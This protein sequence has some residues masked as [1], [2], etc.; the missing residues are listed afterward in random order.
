MNA[1]AY[2]PAVSLR[3]GESTM[4]KS[5][6]KYRPFDPEKIV[7]KSYHPP[8][9]HLTIPKQPTTPPKPEESAEKK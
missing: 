6:P 9:E 8:S 2:V 7:D 1:P 4:N 5:D 3:R